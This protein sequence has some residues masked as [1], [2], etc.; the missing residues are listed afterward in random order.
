[1]NQLLFPVVGAMLVFFVAVPCLTVAARALLAARP[2]ARGGALTRTSS[3]RFSAIVGPTLGPTV[4]LVSAAIHQSETGTPLAACVIDH[5]GD[6]ACRDVVL[7]G[8]LLFA[9]LG[10][11]ALRPAKRGRGSRP[12]PTTRD[13]SAA[14]GRVRAACARNPTLASFASRVHVV[15][16]GVAPACTRGLLRPR[17]EIEAELAER[18]DPD[19]LV[20]TLLHEVE[21]ARSFDPL[22][23][24]VAQVA[25]SVNPLRGLLSGELSRY[26]FTR[27]ALCDR[28]AV[29]AGADPLALAS[30]IVAVASPA[31][32]ASA[33]AA[34]T[35]HGIDGVKLRVQ[36]LLGYAAHSPGPAR[37]PPPLALAAAPVATLA[38]LPHVIGTG[39]L[40]LLH[41]G[42]ERAAL[43]L[44]LG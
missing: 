10:F 29:Q 28:R 37:R 36:L 44:G 21:H 7:F 24:F 39:P 42:V 20:A 16:R 13:L 22:R 34:L 31:P 5:L 26:H 14:A 8:V 6:D 4:W 25:L 12:R 38:M 23:F 27:E 43:V 35:G 2:T 15:D 40:D 3:W 33:A 11:G 32:L 9:I 41:H 30:S 1:M 18:L 17:V 19:E